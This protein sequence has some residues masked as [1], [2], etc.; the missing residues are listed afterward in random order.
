MLSWT[1]YCKILISLYESEH[2]GVDFKA[3]FFPPK[4]SI[5]VTLII[6]LFIYL[7]KGTLTYYCFNSIES[8]HSIWENNFVP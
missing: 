8:T 6:K 2:F 7:W 4:S 5:K 3:Y 1:I